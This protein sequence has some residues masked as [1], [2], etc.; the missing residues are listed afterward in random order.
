M[1]ELLDNAKL[2]AEKLL[3]YATFWK[4]E[5]WTPHT[6]IIIMTLK[7]RKDSWHKD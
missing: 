4:L 1:T 6:L 3:L 7:Q 2:D 5:P